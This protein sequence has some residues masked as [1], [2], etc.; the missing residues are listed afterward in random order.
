MEM[1]NGMIT[2]T[3]RRIEQIYNTGLK[4][5]KTL[6]H[7]RLPKC[8][9]PGCFRKL[10]AKDDKHGHTICE[11][12]YNAERKAKRILLKNSIRLVLPS[13]T[14]ETVLPLK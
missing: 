4:R 6:Y 11:I 3:D 9:Q 7:F 12:C 8:E 1:S 13:E 2:D 10:S 14:R 5:I